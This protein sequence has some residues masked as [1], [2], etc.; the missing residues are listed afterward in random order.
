MATNNES[1]PLSGGGQTRREFITTCSTLTAGMFV[2][3]T[4]I[5]SS[6][7]SPLTRSAGSNLNQLPKTKILV[8][9]AHPDPN[10]PNW[11]NIDYDFAGDIRQFMNQLKSHCPH[12]DFSLITTSDVSKEKA[13]QILSRDQEVD[14]YLVYLSGCLWGD[15][16]ETIGASGKPTILVDHLY[17]GSGEFLT[18]YSRLKREGHKVIGISSSDFKD[19]AKGVE[20]LDAVTKLKNSTMLVLGRDADQQVSAIY[21]T[22]SKTI[23]F[24]EINSEYEKID[25]D[26]ASKVADRWI[27]NAKKV[28][29]PT[30]GEILK[31]AKMYLTMKRLMERNNA[32]AITVNCLGGIYNNRMVTAYPCMG[33]MQLDNE[34]LVGACEADQRSTMTKLLMNYLVHQPGFISDPVIDTSKNQIIYAHCTG[35]TKMYGPEESSN[36]YH[37][38]SHAEDKK[39]AS[40]RSLMPLNKTV[41]TM[42]FD[43]NKKQVIFHQGRTVENVGVERA[44]RTKLAAEVKGDMRKLM[45][46]WDTWGW[47]RVTYYGDH[48]DQLYNIANLLGFEVIEEA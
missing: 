48:K 24:S 37:I 15:L 47:H 27:Y 3:P 33:F 32:Q 41:T 30:R 2:F 6:F 38:R 16:T 23:P 12:V 29:E 18:S 45:E 25:A 28:M 20:C 31:S 35:P 43:H 8:V 9:G 40:I 46:Y 11:P 19:V 1:S 5:S 10:Q 34:G 44:C 39:G 21:G 36:P 7:A 4:F 14:G 17:A 13:R 22:K 26:E 42:Q